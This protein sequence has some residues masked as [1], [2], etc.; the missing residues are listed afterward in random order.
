MSGK[1]IDDKEA[2]S[3]NTYSSIVV[4]LDSMFNDVNLA[5]PAKAYF[6]ITLTFLVIVY[7]P[8]FP[9]GY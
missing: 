5:H 9:P 7:S 8:S 4:M 3:E 1:E 2:H 6:S